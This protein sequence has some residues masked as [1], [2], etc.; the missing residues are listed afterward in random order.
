MAD[1]ERD[2]GCTVCIANYNGEAMLADCID[3][4]LAQEWPHP[5]EIIVHDDA[6]S[7]RSLQLLA[8]YPQVVKITSTQNVGFCVANNR[9]VAR[10]SNAY[11]LLLNNDA[12]LM[13]GALAAMFDVVRMQETSGIVTLPQYD[14]VNGDL[15]DRGCLLDPFYNPS[16]NRDVARTDVAMVIGA[17]LLITRRAWNELGGFPDWFESIGEDLFLCC[18]A[19]LRGLPVQVAAKSGYRH[20]QGASFSGARASATA[21]TTFRRRRLSERNKVS[22][23][24]A[25]TPT[26][27]VWALL[28]LHVVALA[29]EGAFMT[30]ARRDRRIWREI[31][32]PALTHA[33]HLPDAVRHLRTKI[34]AARK[35]GLRVYFAP[36]TIVPF[37]SRALFRHGVPEVR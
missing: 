7:D 5:L 28:T 22:V 4:I 14:W 6:S 33:G 24:V 18:A 16:P 20:R 11:V 31:Y 12:A 10:A 8:A 23:L 2:M 15:V 1:A 29:C 36:F 37:K 27:A 25:C 35:V 30:I 32:A 13:P 17:C 19:R 21:S 34:Q 9:M 3:S 26:W